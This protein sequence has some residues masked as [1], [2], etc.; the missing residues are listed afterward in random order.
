MISEPAFDR[1]SALLHGPDVSGTRYEL[2]SELGRGG[3]GVVYLAR[4]TVLDREV[5][6]KIVDGASGDESIGAA[7][8]VEK[9]ARI[10]AKLEHPGL[11]P[12]H[13]FGQLPDGR[14]FYA[15]KRVRGD[16]LD[17]WIAAGRDVTARLGV[18]LRICDA[19]AFAHAHGVLHRDLKPANVM[20]GEFGEV[21]VLDWGVA[22]AKGDS[23]LAAAVVGTRDYMAP[24]QMRADAHIDERADVFAL[25]AILAGT[26]ADT[27]ALV[28]IAD[29]ARAEDPAAR[30]PSV[31]ALAADVSRFLAGLAVEAHRERV[32]DRIAR[33]VRRYRLPILLVLTYLV[34]RVLLLWLVRV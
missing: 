22:A 12:I 15:M 32:I 19:V 8:A 16:R 25:G 31:P 17:C 27:P 21:L 28:A 5:A 2:V 3:M 6:L 9:E 14:L 23:D 30:Y 4:D 1:L 29:K 26:A 33:V 20:V 24:E 10:L 7:H 11:V 13:D 18:F 34:M